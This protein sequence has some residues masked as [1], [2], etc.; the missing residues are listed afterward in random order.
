MRA[1]AKIDVGAR[2]EAADRPMQETRRETLTVAIPT[3]DAA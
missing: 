2:G 1:A 3:K